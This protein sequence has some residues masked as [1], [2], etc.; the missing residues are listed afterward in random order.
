MRRFLKWFRLQ[1]REPIMVACYVS[2]AKSTTLH[3]AFRATGLVQAKLI[4]RQ[5]LQRH[6]YGRVTMSFAFKNGEEK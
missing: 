5:W 3:D 4:E 6:P 2:I 1:F